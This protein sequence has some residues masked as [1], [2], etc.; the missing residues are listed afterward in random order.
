[1]VIFLTAVL[2]LSCLAM[3]G[4]LYV[5]HWELNTGHTL[6]AEQRPKAAQVLHAGVIII[7]RVIPA[8]IEKGAAEFSV[9]LRGS[10]RTGLARALAASER[11][12]EQALHVLRHKTV[13]PPTAGGEASAFLREVAEHKKKFLQRSEEK[14]NIPIE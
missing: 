5:K 13:P 4:L 14:R 1:M 6:F 10:A 2:V 9:W 11:A 3:A 12:L 7:E 8:A